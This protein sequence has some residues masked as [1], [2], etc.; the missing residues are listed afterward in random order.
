MPNESR[1]AGD[2]YCLL[3]RAHRRHVGQISIS[4][5]CGPSALRD[6][7]ASVFHHLCDT[8]VQNLKR[9][10]YIWFI[11]SITCC[12]DFTNLSSGRVGDDPFT[13]LWVFQFI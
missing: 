3:R 12:C 5:K 10:A 4:S 9:F 1:D 7:T 6:H 13:C 2:Y 8:Y 11:S